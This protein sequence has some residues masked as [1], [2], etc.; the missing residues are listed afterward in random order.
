M[1]SRVQN[2][3]EKLLIYVLLFTFCRKVEDKLP[4]SPI[5]VPFSLHFL[6]IMRDPVQWLDGKLNWSTSIDND[7]EGL[8]VL[9]KL[10]ICYTQVHYHLVVGEW[11]SKE[12]RQ[13]RAEHQVHAMRW[14]VHVVISSVAA[15]EHEVVN[16]AHIALLKCFSA[17]IIDRHFVGISAGCQSIRR[18]HTITRVNPWRNHLIILF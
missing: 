3:Q 15:G 14:D 6:L 11:D 1:D 17:E 9:P 13:G 2:G 7:L 10:E 12:E 8:A 5:M 16:G 18:E 4:V